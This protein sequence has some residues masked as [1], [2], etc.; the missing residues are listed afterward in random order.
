MPAYGGLL[1]A[2]LAVMTAGIAG[3]A[4]VRKAAASRAVQALAVAVAAFAL[5]GVRAAHFAGQALSLALEGQDVVIAGTVDAMP[6]RTALGLR[7]RLA[8]DTAARADGTA[9]ALPPLIEL[10]WYAAADPG[11][12]GS[13]TGAG[14]GLPDL[15]AGERWRLTARLKAPHGARNPHGFDVELWAWEQG[16][17]AQGSVRAGRRDPPPVRLAAAGW[18]RPVEQAR[19]ATR[20]AIYARLAPAAEDSADTISARRRAAGVVAAL[21]VGDQRAIDRADW[22]LFRTTGVAHLM[23]ISGLH[24]TMFAWIAAA[25]VGR[26]WRRVPR[27][28]RAAPAPHAALVGGVLLAAA[29]ATFSGGGLPAQRTV[30]MLATVAA[31]RLS[32]R[33]WPWPPIWLAACAAVVLADPWALLQAGFWLSFVAVGV[34]FATDSGAPRSGGTGVGGRFSSYLVRLLREQCVVTLAL[35]PLTLLLFGQTSAVGLL[36]NLVAIP[37]VTLVVTPLA[38]LGIAAPVLWS[39]AALAVQALSGGLAVLAAWPGA[40]ISL[41]AAPVGAAVLGGG[42]LCLRV[43]PALRLLGAAPLI[44]VLLWPSARPAPGSVE[45]LAADVGQASAVLVRTAQHAL[46]YD[47]GPRYATDGDAGQRV[48]VPLLQSLGVRL[49]TVVVSHRDSDHAGGAPAV[50]AQQPAATLISSVERGHPLEQLR[51]VTRCTAGQQWEWD[52]VR[53]TVLH[54]QPQDYE[55]SVKSNAVSCIL[56]IDAQDGGS[57]LLTGDIEHKQEDALVAA[58][59]PLASHLLLSPHHGSKGSSSTPFLAAVAP[60]VVMVQAGYR[61]RFGHPAPE[62]LARYRAQGSAVFATPACGAARWSSASPTVVRC[63]RQTAARYW[64]HRPS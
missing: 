19:Q 26:L 42:L 29:Y 49:D 12:A 45:L 60:A 17:Q 36:A 31:L 62:T 56:R 51:P 21:V 16:I 46:L 22:E 13:P 63:E 20:D 40:V 41:P 59:A 10:G 30:L 2:A 18:H 24:V 47:T 27:L 9:V 57:A 32:G 50:L 8:V 38:L 43:P 44:P 52:G 23:S 3:P 5:C 34:L 64:Q 1:A 37:W 25:V 11:A 61:N 15:R 39:A 28:C 7:F 4:R 33:D 48:L 58:G 6:Q 54:P 53:F 14:S 55:R 35:A